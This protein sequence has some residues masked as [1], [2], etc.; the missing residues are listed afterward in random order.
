MRFPS[1]LVSGCLLLWVCTSLAFISS[2]KKEEKEGRLSFVFIHKVGENLL[3]KDT[4]TYINAAGNLYEVNELQYF[5]SEITLWKHGQ[6]NLML[7]DSGIH[8]VDIDIPSS[9]SWSPEQEFPEGQYDSISF[10]VG[11]NEEKNVSGYFVNP[12]ER[13]MF[14][15]DVMGGGYHYMKMNGKWQPPLSPLAPFNLHLGL[16]MVEDSAGMQYFIPNYFKVTLPL[17]NGIVQEYQP[18]TMSITM[19]INS[20]FETP[21]KWDWNVTGGQIMQ[22]QEYMHLAALNGMDAFSV[23]CEKKATR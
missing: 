23:T 19:D 9:L 3:A 10:I 15:P 13:D 16:G 6:K 11:L 1:R 2:C 18:L 5:I 7:A 12:P 8:Y 22:S 14:W 17:T 20:C 21:Y 4:L